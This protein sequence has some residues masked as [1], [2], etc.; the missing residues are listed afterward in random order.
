MRVLVTG[1]TGTLGRLLVPRLRDTGHDVRILSRR[2]L[3]DVVQGDLTT[4]AGLDTAVAGVDVIAH[5]ASNP[6]RKTRQTDVEGTRRLVNAVHERG[7]GPLPHLVYVSIVGVDRN[8]FRYY[9]QKLA[10]EHVV[11]ESGLPWTIIRATQFHE[12]LDYA[13]SRIMRGALFAV[14][15]VRFQVIDADECAARMAEL[16][17]APPAGRVPDIGGPEV[18]A[19]NDLA[20]V[21]RSGRGW[22]R[23]VITLPVPG[24]SAAAFK[25]G[26]NLCPDNTYGRVTWEQWLAARYPS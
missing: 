5:C 13:F 3:P 14:R 11:T 19:M 15:G 21:Y 24:K 6:L 12:L 26:T 10:T 18:R 17:G 16:V 20:R 22:R 9:R 23:P 8:P 7:E 25:A 2:A 1:G 4:G